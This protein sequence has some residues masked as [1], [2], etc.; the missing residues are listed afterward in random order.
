MNALQPRAQ[1]PAAFA[2]RAIGPAVRGDFRPRVV[3]WFEPRADRQMTV[4][5]L[6]LDDLRTMAVAG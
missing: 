3:F 2:P 5:R 6:E 1:V 4:S